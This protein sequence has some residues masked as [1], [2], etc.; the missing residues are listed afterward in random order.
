M[1][2]G[3]NEAAAMAGHQWARYDIGKIEAEAGKLERPFKH[4]KTAESAGN[5]HMI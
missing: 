1:A 5:Y 2:S 4:W 3:K